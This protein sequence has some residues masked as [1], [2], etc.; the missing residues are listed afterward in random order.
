MRTYLHRLHQYK[1]HHGP[2]AGIYAR[3][4]RARSSRAYRATAADKFR[5]A[6]IWNMARKGARVYKHLPGTRANPRRRRNV[7]ISAYDMK[8]LRHMLTT[9]RG[10]DANSLRHVIKRHAKAQRNPKRDGSPTRGERKAARKAERAIER[11]RRRSSDQGPV[12]W[13]GEG[14]YFGAQGDSFSNPKRDGS[15]TR[16]ER[17]AMRWG[18]I[19]AKHPS[20]RGLVDTRKELSADAIYSLPVSKLEHILAHRHEYTH[21]EVKHAYNA[22]NDYLTSD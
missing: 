13:I 1:K 7:P 18:A 10:P 6:V 4:D 5:K 17:K 11:K 16:G 15:P 12:D 9:H 21:R 19:A 8:H 22:Y 20:Q 14:Y 2:D 3:M